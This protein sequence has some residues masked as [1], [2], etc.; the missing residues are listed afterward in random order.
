[1]IVIF[2]Q[3]IKRGEFGLGSTTPPVGA[4]ELEAAPCGDGT[5]GILEMEARGQVEL[6]GIC[7]SSLAS[8]KK[9]MLSAS[10]KLDISVKLASCGGMSSMS[11]P[12]RSRPIDMIR[13]F[14]DVFR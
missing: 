12:P 10:V 3:S 11:M 1:V 2:F 6:C 8:V 14:Y 9:N 4:W 13:A 7:G 5:D